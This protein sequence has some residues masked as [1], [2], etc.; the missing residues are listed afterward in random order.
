MGQGIIV[1]FLLGTLVDSSWQLQA[2]HLRR[3]DLSTPYP[4]PMFRQSQYDA[5]YAFFVATQMESLASRSLHN[6]FPVQ[7]SDSSTVN[8]CNFSGV[9]C[10]ADFF[11]NT[12]DLNET[13]LAGE[14]PET[15]GEL[16]RLVRFKA[17]NNS[18]G[19]TLPESLAQVTSLK[20]LNLGHN[21][22]SGPLPDFSGSSLERLILDRNAFNGTVPETLCALQRLS[23]LDLSGS[24][25]LRGN[26]P[27]CLGD[28]TLLSK[29]RVSDSGLTGSV[30]EQLCGERVMNGLRNNTFGCDAIG[31]TAGSFQHRLGRQINNDTACEECDVPSNVIGASL[32]QWYEPLSRQKTPEMHAPSFVTPSPFSPAPSLQPSTA[33]DTVVGG[34]IQPVVRQQGPRIGGVVS[35]VLAALA[36]IALIA[37]FVWKVYSKQAQIPEDS[38]ECKGGD[39]G[40]LT[41][42]HL[43]ETISSTFRF[44]LKG[45]DIIEDNASVITHN[46][47]VHDAKESHGD[48]LKGISVTT[49]FSRKV[50]FVLPEPLAWASDESSEEDSITVKDGQQKPP[51]LA[52]DAE[53]WVSW[54]MNPVFDVA[55]SCSPSACTTFVLQETDEEVAI[56]PS[57]NS[58]ANSLSPILQHDTMPSELFLS[59]A[60]KQQEPTLGIQHLR[61]DDDND[62]VLLE[63]GTIPLERTRKTV[64]P[65]ES[66]ILRQVYEEAVGGGNDD[67]YMYGDASN[68]GPGM[69]EI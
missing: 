19:G 59:T 41:Q 28:L 68:Y 3:M 53:A 33:R 17:F 50:R 58:S 16:S 37:T 27:S 23:A 34:I 65:F 14:L 18:I 30:P 29:L 9:G 12:L 26:L 55:G 43:D 63:V 44:Y 13:M 35:G 60:S 40:E 48:T 62:V 24:T 54:I 10:D 2:T 42:L 46:G 20:T 25:K 52:G 69:A 7:V 61:R 31:C 56:S 32:C 11:V 5:L 1:L 47:Q 22:L 66:S 51:T 8:Y 38:T 36:F 49:P 15:M 67:D 21:T 4:G 57:A 39:H 45:D 64:M 6:W